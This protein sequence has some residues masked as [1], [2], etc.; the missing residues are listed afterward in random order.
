MHVRDAGMIGAVGW[1]TWVA[2]SFRNTRAE[3]AGSSRQHENSGGEV[4][5]PKP[6]NR[7]FRVKT[8]AS[9]TA[10][11]ERR[12]RYVQHVALSSVLNVRTQFRT[13]AVVEFRNNSRKHEE[14]EGTPKIWRIRQRYR[15]NAFTV[16]TN[17]ASLAGANEAGGET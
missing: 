12:R 7:S 17:V 2:V 8:A 6:S 13:D 16:L 3:V 5:V 14:I 4:A 11:S 1:L 9:Q 10:V 15:A